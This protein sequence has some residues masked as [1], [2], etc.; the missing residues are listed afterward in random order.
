MLAD[1]LD[2]KIFSDFKHV[3]M[4]FNFTLVF[5]RGTGGNYLLSALNQGNYSYNAAIN[6]YV[7]RNIYFAK[8]DNKTFNPYD[9][10]R[11]IIDLDLLYDRASHQAALF[12]NSPKH[13]HAACHEPLQLTTKVF[14]F[15]TDHLTY[16]NIT[17]EL[18]EFTCTLA[19]IKH[20]WGNDYAVSHNLIADIINH[21]K[22]DD[23]LPLDATDYTMAMQT[24]QYHLGQLQLFGSPF[25]WIYFMQCRRRR[26]DPRLVSSLQTLVNDYIA[27]QTADYLK[28]EFSDYYASGR[29]DSSGYAGTVN[30]VDYRDLFFRLQ[31]PAAGVLSSLNRNNLAEYSRQNLALMRQAIKIMPLERAAKMSAITDSLESDL[32]RA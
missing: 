15:Y 25:S 12:T 19:W 31:L 28:V 10:N 6:Q 2:H 14:D 22:P 3:Q 4:R 17:P 29:A 20:V 32:D 5:P 1:M 27:D 26:L 9:G 16:I 18:A 11:L 8:L 23:D 13:A 30:E 24:L 21:V 7:A